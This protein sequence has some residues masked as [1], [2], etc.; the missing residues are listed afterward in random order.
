MKRRVSEKSASR[1][2]AFAAL[3]LA[4]LLAPLLGGVSPAQAGTPSLGG[5]AAGAGDGLD[6]RALRQ[7]LDAV[8]EAGM[9][10]I[11][12]EVRAGSQSWQG[13]SGVADVAT[14]RPVK[15]GMLHRVGSITKTFTSVAV[16]QQVARGAV[17]LDAPIGRYL[18]DVVPGERGQKITVRM[19][20][21]HTS[22]IADH[23]LPAF[24]SL[25]QLSPQSID[26]NRFRVFTREELV[27]LG[28]GAAPT[29]EPGA[30]PGV[31]SNTNYLIAGL[32]LERVTGTNAEEYITRNVIRRAGLRH[33]SFP[34]TP[35][36]PGPHSKAYESLY[37][38]I[39]PPRD[40]SVYSPTWITT[41]GSIVSTV[42]DLNRFYRALLRGELIGPAELAEMKRTVP[43]LAGGVLN[44]GL[45]LYS[46]DLPC[47]RFWGHSG[48]VFGMGTDSMTSEDG[49]R[50][51]SMGV[52][53][54]KYQSLDENGA[55]VPH[56]IDYAGGA[57]FL[58]AAC[59][60]SGAATADARAA[61]PPYVPFAVDRV[62]VRR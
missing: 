30:T 29:G 53:R 2:R 32:L 10:G 11:Y 62:P 27:R 16:L 1:R 55:I 59:G 18:P 54:A 15:P 41:A 49:T 44:Y 17:E 14:G 47:G 23:V 48:S 42:D 36:V 43:V 61:L 3:A 13:A 26:D 35:H 58:L 4:A 45:G 46:F 19:L 25:A 6:R 57:Y 20:L 40:Y 22:H 8:H 50:Q 33:T 31:Y 9:Y 60:E 34:R 56:P 52:N 12:S 24:P 28:L 39:D 5:R 51:V 38:S 21:N 37:G 7:A